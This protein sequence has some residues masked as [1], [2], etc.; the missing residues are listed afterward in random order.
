MWINAPATL[1]SSIDTAI[2][3]MIGAREDRAD[4]VWLNAETGARIVLAA[5]GGW[6]TAANSA[7]YALAV[8]PNGD[9]TDASHALLGGKVPFDSSASPGIGAYR[10]R[11]EGA[12]KHIESLLRITVSRYNWGQITPVR[13]I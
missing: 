4:E 12:V 8:S 11:R 13:H 7:F 1:P 10:Q 9:V 6:R 2:T 5:N 3:E